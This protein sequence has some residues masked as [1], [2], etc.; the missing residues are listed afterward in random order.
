MSHSRTKHTWHMIRSL[1]LAFCLLGLGA[2]CGG[3]PTVSPQPQRAVSCDQPTPQSG[4]LSLD[5]LGYGPYHAGQDPNFGSAPSRQEIQADI[6]TLSAL[7]HNI[8]LYASG[9]PTPTILQEAAQAH[10]CV[11]L[12]IW[13]GPDATVNMQEIQ[14]GEMLAANPAVHSVIVGN[15]V[16]LRSDLSVAQLTADVQQVRAKLGHT[17]PISVADDF[18]QWLKHPELADVVDFITVHIYP[19]WNQQFIDNAIPFLN[20]KYQQLRANPHFKGKQIVIGETGWPSD[21]PAQGAAVPSAE[22]QARYLQDF[23]AWAQ[24]NHVHYFYFD[25]FDEAW[26]STEAGVGQHWG[27]LQEN[28]M[29]KPALSAL[30]PPSAPETLTER[31][32][33]DVSVG[34]RLE[35]PF[36]L[37]IDTSGHQQDWVKNEPE[38]QNDQGAFQLA[39]PANQQWGTLFIT[40]GQVGPPGQRQALDLSAYRSLSV[41]LRGTVGGECLRLGIKDVS[42]PDDGSEATVQ[43]CL[44][45][46]WATFT[47]PLHYFATVD[48]THLYVV[49][50]VVFRGTSSNTVELRNVRYSPADAQVPGPITPTAPEFAIY[51]DAYASD[52][53]F[54]PTGFFGD[55]GAITLQEDWTDNPHS[56][57]TCIQVVYTGTSP[58]G[59]GYAGVF[60]QDPAH[61]F[62]STPGGYD[63]SHYHQLT[64]WVRGA[65]GGEQIEFK[66]G[67]ISTG[68]YHDSLVDPVTTGVLTLTTA[69]Q[70]VTMDLTGKDLTHIIGGFVWVTNTAENPQGA[71]FYLDDMVYT[72]T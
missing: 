50:E 59:Y 9:G 29:V 2:A 43:E 5:G 41:E 66:V 10:L 36:S 11:S 28:G 37:G 6:P 40:V 49:F 16:L 34:P 1:A 30:L 46:A 13:L 33:R 21:G 45:T 44:T 51:R 17:V 8:R 23:T 58:Q 67:G 69:W 15:E 62:G 70:Q 35:A 71:T 55:Y 68:P 61:N 31:S 54:F 22:N 26:K 65:Q 3:K 60:W 4:K 24:H 64:F 47:F 39:Y 52:N 27:V 48:L 72:A 19:F 18:G 7:T 42:Q 38:D 20:A 12:G 32:F 57:S 63:L 25:A 56:G 14:R 53:H